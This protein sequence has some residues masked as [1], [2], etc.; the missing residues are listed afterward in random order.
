MRIFA[1]NQNSNSAYIFICSCLVVILIW[2]SCCLYYI[3][4]IEDI[5]IVS[6]IYLV[7]F[8]LFQADEN[9][10]KMNNYR[11]NCIWIPDE[12]SVPF[13]IRKRRGEG[14]TGRRVHWPPLKVLRVRGAP[15]VE[16][17][18]I[19]KNIESKTETSSLLYRDVFVIF[20]PFFI[21]WHNGIVEGI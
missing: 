6:K 19:N 10:V 17:A 13:G 7:Q 8:R 11:K 4:P 16:T 14:A 3:K 9:R 1:E 20:S 5:L 2:S 21:P 18:F 15:P 12:L